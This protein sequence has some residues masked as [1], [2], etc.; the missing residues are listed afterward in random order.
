MRELT[1]DILAAVAEDEI[2]RISA[3]TKA[4]LAAY[5]A[6]GGRLGASRKQCRNLTDAARKKGAKAAALVHQR[7]ADEAYH[8]VVEI[9]AELRDAGYS[10]REIAEH[11][12]VDGFTTRRASRG[13]QCKSRVCW[14]E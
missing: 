3:R 13:T 10:L 7:N 2:R 6:R 5:K 1:I 12:N 14:R 4:A 9:M 11:L 8:D